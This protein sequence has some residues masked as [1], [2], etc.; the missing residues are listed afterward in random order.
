MIG[1]S[2]LYLGHVE[3]SD[4]LRYGHASGPHAGRVPASDR[5]PVVV[6]NVTRR[7]NLACRHCYSVSSMGVS[8]KDELS[9]TEGRALIDDLATF[10]APVLL[11]S[12]GEPFTRPDLL[13]LA[14]HASSAGLRVSVSTNGT[15]IDDGTAAAAKSAGIAYA[16]V[17]VD[18][19]EDTH[20]QFRRQRGAFAAAIEGIR[21]CQRAELK[22][23]LRFTVTR[24]NM[25]D[26][27]GVFEVMHAQRIPRICFYHLVGTGRA[28]DLLEQELSHDETRQVVDAII[29]G[30]ADL[31]SRDFQPE[32]LTVANHA[33]GPYVV[34]RLREEGR[35]AD[36][37]NVLR[38]LRLNG[39]NSTGIGIGCV[40]WDGTVFPDQFWRTRPLGNVRRR[41]FSEVWGDP[42]NA[43]L[44]SLRER[45]RPV[46]GRCAACRFLDTC[47]GNMRARAEAATGML[48]GCDPACYLTDDEIGVAGR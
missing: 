13:D 33:D 10:G 34:L 14:R 35:D 26:I 43:L 24:S 9:T 45:P 40:S 27:P 25:G 32:V 48:W 18:G 37:E 1:I 30:A 47:G 20:D 5:R 17:S 44:R 39:G 46:T 11:L 23:G 3:A 41:P 31:Y 42:G 4:A 36:A 29:S 28:G 15:L 8:C 38:L 19:L 22:V 12:G 2:K 21:A 7:C 6:W 16:G